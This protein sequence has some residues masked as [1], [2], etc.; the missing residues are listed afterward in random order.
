MKLLLKIIFIFVFIPQ[1]FVFAQNNGDDTMCFSKL[2]E[3]QCLKIIES[4]HIDPKIKSVRGWKHV[5]KSEKWKKIF[6]LNEYNED[7]MFC[8][9]KYILDNAM[10]IN[11]YDKFLG[12]EL[13]P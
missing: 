7:E 1:F 12:V 2:S 13:E 5:F 8:L 11:E 6:L 9:E 4:Y 3:D 10:D